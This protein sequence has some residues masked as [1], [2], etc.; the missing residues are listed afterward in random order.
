MI[1]IENAKDLTELDCL[2]IE[3]YGRHPEIQPKL[4]G[5]VKRRRFELENQ[6]SEVAS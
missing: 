2:E 4:M 6:S 1:Q 5:S 3:V